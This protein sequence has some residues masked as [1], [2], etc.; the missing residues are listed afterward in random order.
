MKLQGGIMTKEQ[1]TPK[2]LSKALKQKRNGKSLR[3]IGVEIGL[4]ASTLSRIESGKLPNLTSYYRI[5][6]W[7][8]N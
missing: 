6:K 8:K 3:Q 1:Y 4:S 5:C 7:L 2:L